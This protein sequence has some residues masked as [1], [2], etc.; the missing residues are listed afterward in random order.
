MPIYEAYTNSD[1]TD[2]EYLDANRVDHRKSAIAKL[3]RDER[4]ALGVKE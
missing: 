2:Q 4:I 3:S 1:S